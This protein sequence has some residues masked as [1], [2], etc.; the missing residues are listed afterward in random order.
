MGFDKPHRTDI[1]RISHED[2]LPEQPKPEGRWGEPYISNKTGNP[3]I[4]TRRPLT[5]AEINFGLRSLLAADTWERLQ[6]LQDEEDRKHAAFVAV[7][8]SARATG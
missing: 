1:P 6:A 8:Q 7:N 3:T 2:P 4:A 5:V